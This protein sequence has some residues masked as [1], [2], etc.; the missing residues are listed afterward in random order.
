M[1]FFA[2][3]WDLATLVAWV[4]VLE[5]QLRHGWSG[6]SAEVLNELQYKAI[7]ALQEFLDVHR[8]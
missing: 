6:G 8:V 7:P 4:A 1:K 2:K 3:W 5:V